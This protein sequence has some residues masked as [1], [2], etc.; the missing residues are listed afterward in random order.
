MGSTVGRLW[1]HHPIKIC[2]WPRQ[3][4]RLAMTT[5][6]PGFTIDETAAT[7]LDKLNHLDFGPLAYKL[8]YPEDGTGLS[9]EETADAITKYKGFLFLYQSCE[10]KSISPSRYIDFVWHNHIL[11]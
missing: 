9:L 6:H 11:D 7:F 4:E 10:G 3:Q 5:G 8:M 2:P 1:T